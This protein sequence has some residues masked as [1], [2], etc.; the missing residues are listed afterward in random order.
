MMN[1]IYLVILPI[2]FFGAILAIFMYCSHYLLTYAKDSVKQAV[3]N[4]KQKD[5][6]SPTEE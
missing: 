3:A 4:M 2:L 6:S 1:F 5:E